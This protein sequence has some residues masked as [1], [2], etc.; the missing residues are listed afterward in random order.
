[1]RR[2]HR[3]TVLTLMRTYKL[4][5]EQ[6]LTNHAICW[7]GFQ[8]REPAMQLLN[9]PTALGHERSWDSLTY[10]LAYILLAAVANGSAWFLLSLF[11]C[12]FW[13]AL[14]VFTISLVTGLIAG[15]AS[16]IGLLALSFSQR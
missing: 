8:I 4:Q 9:L 7:A 13:G 12:S 3:A 2:Q 14:S 15:G 16:F 5:Q 1:M 10:N 11:V 6:A